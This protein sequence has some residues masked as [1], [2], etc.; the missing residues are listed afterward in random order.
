MFYNSSIIINKLDSDY[1]IIF[2]I[3]PD[4]YFKFLGSTYKVQKII[5]YVLSL[6]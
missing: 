1:G 6:F 3:I 4:H 5:K 2:K